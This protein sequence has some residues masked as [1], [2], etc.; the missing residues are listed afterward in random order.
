MLNSVLPAS[1]KASYLPGDLLSFR[2]Q[3]P[4]PGMGIMTDTIRLSGA[5]S[6]TD[7]NARILATDQ[8]YWNAQI[9]VHGLIN[10]ISTSCD[11][12]GVLESISDYGRAVATIRA[13][14]QG[15]LQTTGDA[16]CAL[17]LCAP[18]NYATRDIAFGQAAGAATQA[19]PFAMKPKICL[20][21][22]AV[23]DQ[24]GNSVAACVPFDRT[25]DIEISI[26]LSQATSFLHGA[27]LAP[28]STITYS[29]SN[30][31]L[32]YWCAKAPSNVRIHMPKIECL[33]RTLPSTTA[34]F[35][36]KGTMVASRM[37]M[38][39]IETANLQN[40]TFDSYRSVNAG[41][42]RLS[43]TYGD[44]T[45]IVTTTFRNQQEIMANY[46]LAMRDSAS[47]AA[48]LAT[49]VGL[50]SVTTS[51]VQSGYGVGIAFEGGVDMRSSQ[52]GLVLEGMTP[53]AS[54]YTGYLVF[55][56]SF[57]L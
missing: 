30:V 29:L 56:G 39:F 17:E 28:P 51:P 7:A 41:V 18:D 8:V 43:F 48:A 14:E 24:N 45:S 35:Q 47:F 49:V 1:Q 53:A 16:H 42:Q 40:P 55:E 21:G 46:L 22:A 57:V 9:G 10:Q 3:A 25:G 26:I 31:Q 38:S 5:L 54:G 11:K 15:A 32:V 20:N 13:A 36:T 34:S 44:G 4:M 37:L 27:K 6:V 33:Y 12:H 23:I 50:G 2:L 52:L 19:T